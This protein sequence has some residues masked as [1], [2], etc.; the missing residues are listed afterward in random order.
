MKPKA[1][2]SLSH[3][4]DFRQDVERC[5]KYCRTIYNAGY[6]PV[7]PSLIL[8]HFIN[9]DSP[10]G[11]QENVEYSKSEIR[12]CKILVLCDKGNDETRKM[13]VSAAHFYGI[14]TTTLDG[15]LS[16]Y[17]YCSSENENQSI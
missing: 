15:I 14:P 16:V 9:H 11:H 12:R 17:D 6:M 5:R 3:T 1:Y 8:P 7:C 13:E 2:V 10:E 4:G